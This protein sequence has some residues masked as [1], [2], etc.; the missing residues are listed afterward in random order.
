MADRKHLVE[1]AW[2]GDVVGLYDTGNFKIGDTLTQGEDLQYLGI[3]SFSPEL[4]RELENRDPLKTK[5]LETG[6]RQLVDEGVAQWF[7]KE[8]GNRTNVCGVEELQ[9]EVITLLLLHEVWSACA[10]SPHWFC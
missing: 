5:Q 3:P 7:T 1:T 9:F 8:P 10:F 6:V 2:P 4:F